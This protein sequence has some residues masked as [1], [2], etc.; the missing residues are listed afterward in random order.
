MVM[1]RCVFVV[2]LLGSAAAACVQTRLEVKDIVEDRPRYLDEH[3]SVASVPRELLP[4]F[5]KTRR[6]FFKYKEFAV[7]YALKS[8]K[9]ELIETCRTVYLG[10]GL[11]RIDCEL[12]NANG[13]AIG[14]KF[15]IT[16]LGLLTI[17]IQVARYDSRAASAIEEIKRIETFPD[18]LIDAKVG[19]EYRFHANSGT[20]WQIGGPVD[21]QYTL[22]P[23][24]TIAAA[25]IFPALQGDA[26]L[27]DTETTNVNGLRSSK[28]S[29]YYLPYYGVTIRGRFENSTTTEIYEV[30]NVEIR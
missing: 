25:D 21:V 17:R 27:I 8:N 28:R 10:L 6:N 11:N 16:Y 20:E 22:R 14:S 9:D 30:K 18:G 26:M 2:G 5:S 7:T 3:F 12:K 15:Q 19:T 23:T 1:L 13:F 4:Y 29:D 24:Q